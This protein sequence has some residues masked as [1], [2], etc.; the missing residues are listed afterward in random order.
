M[1]TCLAAFFKGKVE[2]VELPEKR[3]PGRPRK[4]RPAVE[5]TPDEELAAEI[6]AL[7]KHRYP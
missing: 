6:R 1:Q 4:E 2:A 5:L 3:K 7:K